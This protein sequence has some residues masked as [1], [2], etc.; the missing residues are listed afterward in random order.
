MKNGLPFTILLV[1]DD[2]DDRSFIDSAFLEVGFAEEV[3]KFINGKMLLHYLEQTEEELLPKLIVLD[4]TLPEL[5]AT[6][7]LHVLKSSSRYKHIP[8]IIFS[9]WITP[10]KRS[11]LISAGAY[12]CIKKGD[13]FHELVSFA[14]KLKNFSLK[15]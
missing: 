1:D 14:L 5:D 9:S 7:I 12:E 8:V 6:D 10:L 15:Q 11:Q 2:E 3:K 13:S 4:N